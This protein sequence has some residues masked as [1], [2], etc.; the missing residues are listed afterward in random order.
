MANVGK[1][2]KQMRIKKHMTQDD[3]AEQLFVSRQTVSNYETGKSNPDVDMLIKI[4]EILDTD[5]NILIYGIPVS[6]DKKREYKKLAVSGLIIF[7]MTLGIGIFTP[8][9]EKWQDNM[10]DMSLSL[11]VILLRPLLLCIIGWFL[12]QAAGIFF[13][14]KPLQGRI[15]TVIHYVILAFLVLYCILIIP[16][17][18][19]S[20]LFAAEE[21]RLMNLRVD[22]SS[23][24]IEHLLPDAWLAPIYAGWSFFARLHAR[25]PALYP[26]HTAFFL[27]GMALWGTKRAEY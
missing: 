18:I 26:F 2:I 23:Q 27:A 24:D 10:F 12:M 6:P 5:M 1:N 22:F 9:A 14:A 25:F 4:A 17:C 13:K 7:F 19:D 16:F 20:A 3:L 8:Y 11:I 21:M 15:F